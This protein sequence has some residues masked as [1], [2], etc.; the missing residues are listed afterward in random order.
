[1]GVGNERDTTGRKK[2]IAGNK[3]CIVAC[4]EDTL[5]ARWIHHVHLEKSTWWDYKNSEDSSSVW[6][7]IMT[8]KEILR[9]G[10]DSNISK[11]RVNLRFILR[12]QDINGYLVV[13]LLSIGLNMKFIIRKQPQ[14]KKAP[15][16]IPVKQS[17][18]NCTTL[19]LRPEQRLK[20]TTKNQ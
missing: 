6:R 18:L 3:R 4:K 20:L 11:W 7:Q 10:F 1:L 5:W 19:N 16:Q 15:Q 8:V 13:C 17:K 14:I 12:P 2:Y 9:L